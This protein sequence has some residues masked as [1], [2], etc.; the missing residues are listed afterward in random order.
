M[1]GTGNGAS[2]GK[3]IKEQGGVGGSL[4]GLCK[5]NVDGKVLQDINANAGPT[6]DWNSSATLASFAASSK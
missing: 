1:L 3:N 2:T 5:R 4:V 6:F